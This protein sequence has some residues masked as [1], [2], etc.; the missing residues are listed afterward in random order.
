[1]ICAADP[2][3]ATMTL[4]PI[5][6]RCINHTLDRYL[7]LRPSTT[8]PGNPV[9]PAPQ[10]I[11]RNRVRPRRSHNPSRSNLH[12][13]RQPSVSLTAVSFLGGFRTP[14]A[15]VRPTAVRGRHPKP[16]TKA[17][18]WARV[19]RVRFGSISDRFGLHRQHFQHRAR[20]FDYLMRRSR[21]PITLSP[22]PHPPVYV[23]APGGFHRPGATVAA[24]AC[25][26]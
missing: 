6:G 9:D 24:P 19:G 23:A 16:F 22:T 21:S 17:A 1:M 10:I 14:A 4:A 15:N 2:R 3:P 11:A 13:A 12:S 20:A 5:T 8:K 7:P 25:R 26:I 18:L